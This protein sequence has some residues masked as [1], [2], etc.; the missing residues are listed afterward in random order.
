MWQAHRITAQQLVVSDRQH[1]QQQQ[2]QLA[3]NWK[4]Q[5]QE[6]YLVTMTQQTWA[7]KVQYG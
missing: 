5:Q 6:V 2:Q 4:T 1:T 7:H 3:H